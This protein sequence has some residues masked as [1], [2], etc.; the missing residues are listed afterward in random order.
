MISWNDVSI[1][2]NSMLM[3]FVGSLLSLLGMDVLLKRRR[4]AYVWWI[5]LGFRSAIASVYDILFLHGESSWQVQASFVIFMCVTAVATY[6]VYYYTWD[7]DILKAGL[8]GIIT[9]LFASFCVVAGVAV[10]NLICGRPA[11]TSYQTAL[12]PDSVPMALCCIAFFP[13]ARI[14]LRL[15]ARPFTT[16]KIRF[17]KLWLGIAVV[18]IAIFTGTQFTDLNDI[19]VAAAVIIFSLI[20]IL[21]AGILIGYNRSLILE[22]RREAAQSQR[23]LIAQQEELIRSQL[24]TLEENRRLLEESRK[25]MARMKE[26]GA[27]SEA[28]GD[29]SEASGASEA[30]GVSEAFPAL[31]RLTRMYEEICGGVYSDDPGMDAVISGAVQLARREG[32]VLHASAQGLRSH[33]R[34]AACAVQ[35]LLEWGIAGK[36]EILDM[37]IYSIRN[38]TVISMKAVPGIREHMPEGEL[39]ELLGE[40]MSSVTETRGKKESRAVLMMEEA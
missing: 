36:P 10:V 40:K 23:Q 30:D 31:E 29:A 18:M 26:T 14:L 35:K 4:G 22:H 7:T 34:D 1:F 9:E 6:A 3:Y 25:V 38:Q 11:G 27:T 20:C 12:R 8:A 28:G 13:L 16:W 15:L 19:S 2:L 21:G 39:K 5:Y 24:L 32:I 33:D 17:R 37:E